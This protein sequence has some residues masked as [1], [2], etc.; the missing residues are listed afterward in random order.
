MPLRLK[1]LAALAAAVLVLIVGGVGYTAM[2]QAREAALAVNRTAHTRN[3][4]DRTLRAVT[5]A[6]SGQ[7]GYLLTGDSTYLVPYDT[8]RT[9][10]DHEIA[11]LHGAL[12]TPLQRARLDSL[13]ALADAKL[14]ELNQTITLREAD[15]TA[16]VLRVVR[17]GQ[18][19][20]LSAA[21]R[22][23]A[24]RMA[25]EERRLLAARTAVYQQRSERASVI[26]VAG[27]IAAAL[28][29]ILSIISIRTGVEELHAAT[30]EAE[31][32]R[33]RFQQLLESTDEGIYGIDEAS[34]CSFI[35]TAGAALLG[36]APADVLGRDTHALFHHHHSD[37]RP[38]AETDCPIFHALADGKP[39]RE[40]DELFWRRDGRPLPVEYAASP[41]VDAGRVIGAVVAFNDITERKRAERERERLIGALARSNAELDQFAY[42]ASHDLKAPLRGIANL[43]EWIEED[44]GD[45]V[46]EPVREKMVLMRGRVH[47]LEALIDGILQYSRAG[48]VRAQP[49]PVDVGALLQ[50]VVELLA[51]PP[52][53]TVRIAPGMPTIETERTPLQQ[54]FMNLI[55][56]AIKY[57]RRPGATVDV[58]VRDAG[59]FYAFSVA[60]NGPGI[61]PEYHDRIFGIFQTLESRD[62][63]EGT[64]IG[65]SVVKKM[66]EL[67]GGHVTLVSAPEQGATFTFEWPRRA[68]SGTT[69][70]N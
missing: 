15:D 51:P 43:S 68:G 62:R 41:I 69:D 70:G 54:V 4:L 1:L 35:N 63:V 6:E 46:P 23:L 37:G 16:G 8:A 56:N 47:R 58:T 27:S 31:R 20:R 18:G 25:A 5:E 10:I 65:L 33:T 42:V 38:Y 39:A 26:I 24:G 45:A 67:R 11:L 17:S 32:A 3:E 36:Y 40:R 57:N 55:G 12:D 66:V 49:E 7:R 29:S 14:V 52:E 22:A 53:V 50:E 2:G 44:L 19:E 48:R 21:M 34:R 28:L 64:G 30:A 59:P 60:D 13:A 61:A 9:E